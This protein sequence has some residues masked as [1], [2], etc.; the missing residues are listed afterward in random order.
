[1]AKNMFIGSSFVGDHTRHRLGRPG[2]STPGSTPPASPPPDNPPSSASAIMQAFPAELYS[3]PQHPQQ[4]ASSSNTNANTNNLPTMPPLP[5]LPPPKPL[6][7]A[8]ALELRLKWLEA[9][10]FGV[11][12]GAEGKGKFV[13]KAGAGGET[14]VR[15]TGELQKRMDEIIQ[16]HD[17]LRRFV[18]HYQQHGHLLTPA[19]ALSGSLPSTPAYEGMSAAELDAFLTEL[20]PDVRAAD[21]DMREIALL[22]EKGVTGAGKLPDYEPL[23]PRLDTL[24]E[25]YTGDAATAEELEGRVAALIQQYATQVD[26]LSELFVEWDEV[27]R[28]A[29][30][31]IASL[32]RDKAERER[33]G[34]E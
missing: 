30:N 12:S 8:Q 7:P 11:R 5:Q 23:Q 26:S 34:Y 25:K 19:F 2:G 14:L 33:L 32:E 21:R 17:S 13:E 15:S 22:E 24:V 27:L 29:E 3:P 10:L 9:I 18:D 16:A 4:S 31:R 6:D 20:E 1:M 28:E